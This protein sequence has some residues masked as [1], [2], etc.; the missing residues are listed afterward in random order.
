MK[1]DPQNN[2]RVLITGGT[3]DWINR[4]I[5]LR[6]HIAEGFSTIL[7]KEHVKNLP[8]EV[9]ASRVT[10]SRPEMV[11]VLGSCLPDSCDYSGL[12][13]ACDQTGSI[14]AFWLHDD[15]YEFDSNAKIINIA[16]HIF[17]SDRWAS[18]HYH[19]ANVWH[20]PLAASQDAH[21]LSKIISEDMMQRDVFFCGVG[22][23]NRRMMLK[24]LSAVLN[25]VHT[26]ICGDEWNIE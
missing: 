9:A 10:S 7:G 23:Q 14:L 16:D 3:P 11:L 5:I 1:T 4:N 21:Q 12:R 13:H 20:L 26:E 25:K 8:L 18:E 17:S 2:I 15:P 24:D 19:R 6:N 22:F